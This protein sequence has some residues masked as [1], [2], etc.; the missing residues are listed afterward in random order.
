MSDVLE[1]WAKRVGAGARRQRDQVRAELARSVAE[2]NAQLSSVEHPQTLGE[3]RDALAQRVATLSA[4]REQLRE[5]LARRQTRLRDEARDEGLRLL[6]LCRDRIIARRSREDA[7]VVAEAEELL[8][9]SDLTAAA[10][11]GE[12]KRRDIRA[13]VRAEVEGR[14]AAV[15][16]AAK[17]T[18]GRRSVAIQLTRELET[19]TS[20][21]LK[22]RRE[23][24]ER[25]AVAPSVTDAICASGPAQLHRYRTE[26]LDPALVD[27][28]LEAAWRVPMDVLAEVRRVRV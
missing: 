9:R 26:V 17:A 12:L 27:A 18:D 19:L 25:H 2:L 11:E 1:G 20:D 23:L 13:I 28:S 15:A 14:L 5:E 3:E 6:S 8:K 4:R 16:D 24:T 22:L 21:Q 10:L 7:E